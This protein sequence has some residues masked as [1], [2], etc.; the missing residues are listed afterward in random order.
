MQDELQR[1]SPVNIIRQKRKKL[2]GTKKKKPMHVVL[3]PFCTYCRLDVDINHCVILHLLPCHRHCCCEL[4]P[5]KKTLHLFLRVPY[6]VRWPR[7]PKLPRDGNAS[8]KFGG[9]RTLGSGTT[10]GITPI[11]PLEAALSTVYL[12][13]RLLRLVVSEAAT[14]A[15]VGPSQA[16]R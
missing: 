11:L 14:A 7:A 8:T 6:N 9:N 16:N 4:R 10:L 1:R 13:A 3:T 5:S 2:R 12:E 15:V